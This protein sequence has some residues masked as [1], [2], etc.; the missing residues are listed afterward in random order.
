MNF[1]LF[2]FLCL[3]S[4]LYAFPSVQKI[5]DSIVDVE[6]LTIDGPYGNVINGLS[7][8]QEAV[9]THNGWQYVGYYNSSR[10]VCLSRRQLPNGSWERIEFTD[11][12]FVSDDAHN[13]ISVGICPNDG[14]IHLSF[15]QHAGALHY[16]ISQANAATNPSTVTWSASL[17]GPV[18]DF[19]ENGKGVSSVTYPA[20]FKTP[21]GDMQMVY[22][23]G[24]S[25]NG[26]L[27]LVDYSGAS[28]L[29]SNTRMFISRQGTFTDEYNT[30]TVRCAYPNRY[31]YGLDGKLHV[32]W[33]WRENTHANHDVMY[34]Y[35]DDGG[36]TWFNNGSSTCKLSM[37]DMTPQKMVPLNGISTDSNII[38]QAPASP[39]RI[40]SPGVKVVNIPRKYGVMNTQ[41][42]AVDAQGRVHV[43]VWHCN[44]ESFAYAAEQGYPHTDTWGHPLARRYHHYWRDANG[45]WRHN[46]MK[47]VAGNRPQLYI[48]PNGDA[49]M[50]YNAPVSL[51]EL[52][53]GLYFNFGH[54]TIAAATG[55]SKWTD[56]Q[57]IHTET[58]P[59]LNEMLAD[60]VRFEQDQVLSIM[61]QESP[62]TSRLPTPLKIIEYTLGP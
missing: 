15:D 7:F 8:Q 54:L 27:V 42:Q 36:T 33:V 23:T 52:A 34:S 11:Y 12:T 22:R 17:F 51:T 5:S 35:S 10:H 55:E 32:T 19:L 3:G 16:R 58:G 49:F 60:P 43:V 2:M 30:N 6:A 48:R 47:W 61:V 29:W 39:I 38:G 41:A 20:F 14:T 37:N 46:E 28:H 9:I 26:D 31:Q 44:D 56:W 53:S 21:G 4:I 50:I 24:G 18:R 59:F 62:A 25:G 40:D 1:H 13:T 45:T 57:V